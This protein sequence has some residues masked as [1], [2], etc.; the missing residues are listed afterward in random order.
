MGKLTITAPR[1]PHDLRIGR[2]VWQ[3]LRK[4]G[5]SAALDFDG[6]HV[7]VSMPFDGAKSLG[8]G[9]DALTAWNIEALQEKPLPPIYQAGVRYQREPM[10]RSDGRERLCEEW[11]T[12]HESHA[13]GW[14]DCDDLGP[15]LAADLRIA[16]DKQAQAIAR[17]SPA[18]WHIVVRRGD[19]SIEDPSAKLGMPTS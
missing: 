16:G 14:G 3:W 1:T 4:K 19:G 8:V 12:A 15:W 17:P 18:G 9:L 11:L 5:V 13:R 7:R 6:S 10:C 2:G